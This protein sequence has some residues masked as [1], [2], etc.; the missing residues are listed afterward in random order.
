MRWG[1]GSGVCE[2]RGMGTR[3]REGEEEKEGR[4]T[5]S[6][7]GGAG[8]GEEDDRGRKENKKGGCHSHLVPALAARAAARGAGSPH[9]NRQAIWLHY[10]AHT[11]THGEKQTAWTLLR[12]PCDT[13]ARCLACSDRWA[14]RHGHFLQLQ[15]PTG[16]AHLLATHTH[17]GLFQGH[18]SHSD[19][20][21]RR[22]SADSSV[23]SV[24]MKGATLQPVGTGPPPPLLY[25]TFIQEFSLIIQN[26]CAVGLYHM[27]LLLGMVNSFYVVFIFCD[28]KGRCALVIFVT[29]LF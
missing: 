1:C 7:H 19:H 29:Y 20:G 24:R 14:G 6:Q 25:T 2:D 4:R 15:G 9:H 27:A 12:Q 13:M 28:I 17:E 8:A 18:L 22:P 16:L 11:H 3:R 26:V 10:E 23:Q 21:P 5:T